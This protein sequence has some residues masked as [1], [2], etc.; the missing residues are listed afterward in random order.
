MQ[1]R[2]TEFPVQRIPVTV[3]TQ[4]IIESIICHLKCRLFIEGRNPLQSPF[5]V[6]IVVPVVVAVADEAETLSNLSLSSV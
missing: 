3:D 6:V 4:N 2:E 1:I 5:I